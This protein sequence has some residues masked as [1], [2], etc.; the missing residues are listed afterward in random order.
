MDPKLKTFAVSAGLVAGVA[1]LTRAAIRRTRSF[2]WQNKSVVLTG[3][4]RGLGLCMA[5]QLAEAGANLTICARTQADIERAVKELRTLSPSGQQ[6]IQGMQCDVREKG[7]TIN[8]MEFVAEQFGGVD[9]LI[10]NAGIIEVG[11]LDSMTDANFKNSMDTHCWG[12][13]NMVQAALPSMRR[14]GWGR[15]LNIVSLGG[16][17]AVPHMIPY[18]ASK[19]ALTGLSTGLRSELQ[20][21][22]ILVTTVFPGLMRT[23]SPRNATFKGQHRREYAWFSVSDSL[24]LLS[25]SATQA[26]K[27]ILKACQNGD[28][29]VMIAGTLNFS[30]YLATLA[31]NLASE[32]MALINSFLPEM[33]GIGKR[34]AKGF[35]SESPWSPS[36]LTRMTD[37]AAV[38]NNQLPAGEA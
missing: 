29:E 11:P 7:Q 26:A 30:G 9:V 36:V 12:T 34:A 38:E 19:F 22:N 27:K 17:R 32:V 4:S 2:E 16:K 15:I 8:L 31:P 23:G 37:T 14:S 25:T 20:R 28:A 13:L 33:G 5:R 3:G 6:Q 1:W 35:E 18:A 21:E 10:N 24:P